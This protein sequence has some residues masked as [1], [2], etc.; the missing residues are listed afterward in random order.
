MLGKN[1]YLYLLE[2]ITM[3]Q[4]SML[5]EYLWGMFVCTA[6]NYTES[7]CPKT[8]E[9]CT[10]AASSP[11]GEGLQLMELSKQLFLWKWQT[12]RRKKHN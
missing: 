5:A 4:V 6:H 12:Q 8:A 1:T 11:A 3:R 2:D 7:D 9:F 10:W